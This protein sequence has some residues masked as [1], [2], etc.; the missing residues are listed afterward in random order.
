MAGAQLYVRHQLTTDTSTIQ[1]QE[2]SIT[3]NVDLIAKFFRRLYAPFIGIYNVTDTLLDIL[4]T[5]TSAGID[6]LKGSTAPRV[7]GV[8]REGSISKIGEDANMPDT[9]NIVLDVSIPYPLNNIKV[10]LLV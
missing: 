8:L 5:M 10:T 4:K 9:V 7:G 3:K 1:Y 2:L 6:Y